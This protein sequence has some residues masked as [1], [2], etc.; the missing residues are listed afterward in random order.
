ME[1][2]NY[3][4]RVDYYLGENLVSGNFNID[5]YNDWITIKDL[6]N[7]IIYGVPMKALLKKYGYDKRRFCYIKGD[8]KYVCHL[9]TFTK[10]RCR[11]NVD[12]VILRSLAFS[13]HWKN[14]YNK[15]ADIPF[16]KKKDKVF[17]RGSTTGTISNSVN[18]FTLLERWF[19]KDPNINIGFSHICQQQDEYKKYVKG[20]CDIKK[21]LEFKYI[22]SVAGN[23][24]D[25]GLNWKL[26]SNSVVMMAR[27]GVTSWLME[28]K[29]IPD[30]HYVL[31]KNDFSDLLEKF[32]WCRQNQG[33]CKEIVRNSNKYMTQFANKNREKKIEKNVIDK[34]FAIIKEKKEDEKKI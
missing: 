31:L 24:K 34:Y 17:W 3:E 29:L 20:K 13:R 15:V 23:D 6:D 26:N 32:E 33:K 1:L 25:S 9:L 12:S 14:Y 16:G 21:F 7:I 10:V 30:Y 28:T 11:N 18:R 4:D 5:D 2:M 27:P 22:L 8:I 19:G